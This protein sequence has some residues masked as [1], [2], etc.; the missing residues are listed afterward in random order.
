MQIR[1]ASTLGDITAAGA[2]FREY[3]AW[4]GV[5]LCFQ[6]FA[7]ELTTLPGRYAAPRGRLLIAWADGEPAG[8]VALRPLSDT[9]CEMKRLFVKPLYRGQGLGR[10]LAEKVVS[11]ARV[12]GYSSMVLDTLPTMQAALQLYKALGFARCSAYYKTPLSGTVF[13]ELKL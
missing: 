11:E 10:E 8:C 5:D 2:L 7:E 9:R 1:E 13:M 3:A 4:L 6:G 12:I